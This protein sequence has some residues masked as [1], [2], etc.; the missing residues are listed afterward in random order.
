MIQSTF[1]LKLK[2]L[3]A[4]YPHSLPFFES[5]IMHALFCLFAPK[6]CVLSYCFQMILGI[7]RIWKCKI[8]GD[9]RV[10]YGEL[11]SR[12]IR[13]DTRMIIVSFSSLK[14]TAIIVYYFISGDISVV[15]VNTLIFTA[16]KTEHNKISTKYSQIC[17]ISVYIGRKFKNRNLLVLSNI[18]N[19]T[20]MSRCD[21][22]RWPRASREI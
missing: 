20:S 22:S 13:L 2:A 11:E 12:E 5:P 14:S 19:I 1:T 15:W 4:V 3:P 9:N 6:F 10:N 18:P 21:P 16:N 7:C 17:V 8:W